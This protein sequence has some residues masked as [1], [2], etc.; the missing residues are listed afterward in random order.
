MPPMYCDDRQPVV[1]ERSVER[2]LVVVRIDVAQE[3]PRG[4]DEGVHRV[5]LAAPLLPAAGTGHADPVLVGGQRRLPLR[6]VV[7]DVGQQQGQLVV[8]HRH[9]PAV[10]AVDDRDR[11]APVAL[12]REAPV[13]ET[14]RDRRRAL[15]PSAQPLDDRPLRLGRRQAGEL[16]GVDEHLVVGVRRER[17]LVRDVAVGRGDDR[18]NRQVERLRELVSP[19]RRARARP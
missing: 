19:A 11:A 14:V 18:A 13:A 3:V 6:R 2:R 17:A 5:G 1:D 4:V 15:P 8:G 16:A 9:G 12:A 10:V 7:L